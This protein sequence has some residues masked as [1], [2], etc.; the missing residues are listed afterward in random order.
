MQYLSALFL[1]SLH[2]LFLHFLTFYL[3]FYTWARAW[4]DQQKWYW[5]MLY[6]TNS[7]LLYS[8]YREYSFLLAQKGG[9]NEWLDGTRKKNWKFI[10][11]PYKISIVPFQCRIVDTS[12]LSALPHSVWY[13]LNCFLL[14]I[15]LLS[16]M[17]CATIAHFLYSFDKCILNL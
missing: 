16:L 10:F 9:R 17:V 4:H 2:L 3:P 15:S 11:F 5:N 8:K 7:S 6:I 13:C 14:W 12:Y 1:F